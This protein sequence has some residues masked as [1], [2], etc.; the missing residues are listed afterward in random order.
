MAKQELGRGDRL[1]L[2]QPPGPVNGYKI[3]ADNVFSIFV[4]ELPGPM[5]QYFAAQV[6]FEDQRA[7]IVYPLHMLER[8]DIQ[9]GD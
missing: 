8:F 2:V 6:Q 4:I 7:D 1:I 9:Y 3:G 5:G